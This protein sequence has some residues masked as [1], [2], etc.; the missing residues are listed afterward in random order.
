MKYLGINENYVCN[1]FSSDAGKKKIFRLG[2]V[3]IKIFTQIKK[4]RGKQKE[5]KEGYEER[6]LLSNVLKY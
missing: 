2:C 6:I 5:E 3:C 1:I 4:G